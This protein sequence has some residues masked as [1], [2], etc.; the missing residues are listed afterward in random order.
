M[1]NILDKIIA[2]K[3]Q[4][5][6][7]RK[8]GTTL[9]QLREQIA[10]LPRCRNFYKAVTKPNRRGLNVIAE[11]KKASPSR[12]ILCEDLDPLAVAETYVRCNAA[13]I[14]VLTD[15]PYFKGS[16]A[17]LMTVKSRMP[18]IPVLRKDF[19]LEPYQV[20][21]ARAAGADAL[22]LIAAILDD[23]VLGE[24]LRLSHKLGMRCLV[25]VH[26]EAELE[27]A[28]T[29]QAKIIGI[30]NRNLDTMQVDINTTGRLRP[31]IPADRLVVGES[32]IKTRHDVRRMRDWG[33]DAVLVGETLVTAGEIAE[34][35]NELFDED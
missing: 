27:R 21:E 5:V 25:E 12:G 24:L 16:L 35:I 10:D 7:R 26:N 19:I 11:I 13:A 33:V 34:K 2:D 20:F 8:A 32:G 14:S 4:E 17:D 23:A 30:N 29:S 22:L 3:R 6:A 18:N 9:E 28:L 31:L 1:A 15:T